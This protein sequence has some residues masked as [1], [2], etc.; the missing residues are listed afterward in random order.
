MSYSLLRHELQHARLL[1]PSLSPGVCSNLCPLSQ[2]C[3]LTVS[4][5]ATSFSFC[6]QSFPVSGSFPISQFFMLGSQSTRASA[7][8]SPSNEYSELISFQV[9]WFD[10]LAVPRTLLQHHKYQFFGAQSSLWSN[11]HVPTWLLEKP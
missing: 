9:D 11:S 4:S 8:A 1:C 5:S 6:L 7:S 2:W 10:L 3:Y